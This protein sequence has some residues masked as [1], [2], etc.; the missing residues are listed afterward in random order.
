MK[1]IVITS[2]SELWDK[3]QKT[4]E[5]TQS[6]I[7]STLD[8]VGFIHATNPD[9]TTAMLNRHF[10]DRDDLLLLTIDLDKVDPEV[11]FEPSLTGGTETYPHIYGALN[12]DAVV[13]LRKPKK[14][15][16]GMFID[17]NAKTIGD[18]EKPTP[19]Q[20]VIT[21]CAFIHRE[22]DGV[23]EVFMAKRADTKRFLP[24]VYELPGGH[25]EFGEDI[26]DGLVREIREEFDLEARLGD[27]FAVFT[28]SNEIKGSHSIEVI[29]F[30]QLVDPA[31]EITPNPEDHSSCGWFAESELPKTF[32]SDKDAED[33]EVKAI[34]R[35][36]ALLNGQPIN[37]ASHPATN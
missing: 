24:G 26:T 3:A 8:K 17:T 22:V 18:S 5:Y 7:N 30:A 14:N 15:D 10:I 31:A 32:T 6:T 2:T 25:I 13:G 11:K 27:P 34:Y 16:A 1:T 9:Q 4:G 23:H 35:G 21:A 19:G 36:F 29:Y 28:Y 20:Q 12:T 33:V 37:T